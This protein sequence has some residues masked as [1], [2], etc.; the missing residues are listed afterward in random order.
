MAFVLHTWGRGLS[1]LMVSEDIT[2][3]LGEALWLQ[4]SRSDVTA[5]YCRLDSA[6]FCLT[7][8]PVDTQQLEVVFIP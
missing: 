5:V 1:L 3:L 7:I 6:L 4:S 8:F 2:T